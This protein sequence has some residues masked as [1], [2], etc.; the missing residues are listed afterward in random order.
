M[1]NI[2][3]LVSVYWVGEWF[4]GT[5]K[6]YNSGDF[7]IVYEDGDNE[8]LDKNQVLSNPNKCQL[9][10]DD[11]PLASAPRRVCSMIEVGDKTVCN[12]RGK[13]YL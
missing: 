12:Y 9:V 7:H 8:W 3:R 5:I 13:G 11:A 4:Q 2:G 1:E 6:A 10:G